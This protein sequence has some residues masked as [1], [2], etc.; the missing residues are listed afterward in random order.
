MD[1]CLFSNSR[2]MGSHNIRFHR[3]KKSDKTHIQMAGSASNLG[4]IAISIWLET[5]KSAL[6]YGFRFEIH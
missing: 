5:W 6:F 1:F 2:N 3:A 4:R